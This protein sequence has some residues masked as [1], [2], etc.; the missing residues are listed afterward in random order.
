MLG[1]VS[2]VVAFVFIAPGFYAYPAADDFC[3]AVGVKE[4]GLFEQLWRHYFEWS[5]RYTGNFL[6]AAYPLVFGL[7]EGYGYIAALV[8]IG[9]YF[10]IAFLLASIFQRP[11][12]SRSVLLIS[13][14]F[15][16]V[17][18][19]GVRHPASSLYWM[20]GSLSYQ[21]AN[22]FLL[23]ILGLMFRMNMLQPDRPRAV[24]FVLL[25]ISISLGIGTNETGMLAIAALAILLS[26]RLISSN[27]GLT[28]ESILILLLTIGCVAIVYFSPGNA[29]RQSTLPLGQDLLAA[30]KGSL[31]MGLWTLG[32]WMMRPVFIA[33]T[34]FV[35][36]V[37]NSLTRESE[38]V[39]IVKRIDLVI[40]FILTFTLPFLLQFP[41]W[42]SMGGWPPPRTVDAIFFV[43]LVCWLFFVGMFARYFKLND[44]VAKS[45]WFFVIL[46]GVLLISIVSDKRAHRM[47][48]DLVENVV[49][50]HEYISSRHTAIQKAISAENY[51]VTLPSYRATAPKSVYFN[52]IGSNP[53]DW[54]NICY[55][56]YFGLLGV[57]RS[58]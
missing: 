19:L 33:T 16:C 55:A 36:V 12:S 40:I 22:I 21:S 39:L 49:P 54:R 35:P 48:I 57:R 25:L 47:A 58:K 7:F 34:L 31:E 30:L 26:L 10:S 29:I 37:I 11:L 2:L 1:L 53:Y 32:E 44:R 17:F 18:L 24:H 56:Q 41:A 5:G 20:A 9:L 52:D 43:F 23:L 14:I 6:Y 38:S 46:G 28:Y 45:S 51:Y 13:L 4:Y 27:K 15:L 42:W 3:M 8:M 50:F